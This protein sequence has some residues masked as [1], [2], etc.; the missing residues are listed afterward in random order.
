MIFKRNLSA[1]GYSNY[2]EV[3]SNIPIENLLVK[4]ADLL[5]LTGSINVQLRIHNGLPTVFEIN[6]RISSTV[7]VRDL[8]GFNDVLWSIQDRSGIKLSSYNKNAN[9]GS[10]FY[11]GFSEHIEFKIL[12]SNN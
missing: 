6:P 12:E 7:L 4:I 5:N 2:G 10:K 9:V 3:I 11:K 1:G 8:L